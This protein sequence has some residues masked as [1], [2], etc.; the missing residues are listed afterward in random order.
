MLRVVGGF[1]TKEV[2]GLIRKREGAV[3]V[4]QHRALAKLAAE[5]GREGVTPERLRAM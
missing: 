4:L 3:R 5:L 2:A 1:S